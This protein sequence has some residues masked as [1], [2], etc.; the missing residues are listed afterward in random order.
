MKPLRSIPGFAA[1]AAF[2]IT[3]VLPTVS[4]ADGTPQQTVKSLS[5]AV[6]AVLQDKGASADQK[7]N[8]I[9][10]IVKQY[11]DFDTMSRLILARNWKALDDGKKQLFVEEFR[12]HLSVTYGR[13]VESYHDEKVQVIGDRDEG[14]GDWTVQTK[15][16]RPG[17]GA[18]ILVDYRLRQES[19]TWKVIDMV[20]ERVSLVSNYRSQFQDLM[21]NGGIDKVLTVLREKNAAGQPLKAPKAS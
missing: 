19:G 8:K 13:N 16:L 6:I 11:T 5:D 7:R 1:L 4:N 18:D 9:Q 15:I 17:G 2:C 3:L 20:I 21:A 14:R 10:E 12:E